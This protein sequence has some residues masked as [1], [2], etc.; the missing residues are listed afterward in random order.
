M[1]TEIKEKVK[2][3]TERMMEAFAMEAN[4]KTPIKPTDRKAV[5]PQLK[6]CPQFIAK[7]G[8]PGQ[9]CYEIY[10][11]AEPQAKEARGETPNKAWTGKDRCRWFPCCTRG[12]QQEVEMLRAYE[13]DP[14]VAAW[15]RQREGA[16]PIQGMSLEPSTS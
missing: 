13:R 6:K 14:A 5:I 9:A 1:P 3:Y 16:S 15:K 2:S 4:S 11:T 8:E 7:L 10:T 12:T